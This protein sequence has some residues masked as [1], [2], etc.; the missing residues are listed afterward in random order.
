M[1]PMPEEQTGPRMVVLGDAEMMAD[2]FISLGLT[3]NAYFVLNSVNWLMENEK[4][5]SITPKTDLPRFLTMSAGQKRL[6][7]AIVVG[8]VPVIII[9]VGFTVWWRRR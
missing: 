4:L 8:I 2:Q 1:M 3:G 9:L 6:V 5:I 7:W